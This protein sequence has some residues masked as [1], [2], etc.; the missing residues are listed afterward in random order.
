[1]RPLRYGPQLLPGSGFNGCQT[2]LD[3][4]KFAALF[5][6]SYYHPACSCRLGE[7]GLGL[8]GLDLFCVGGWGRWADRWMLLCGRLKRG[9]AA[10]PLPPVAPTII[11]SYIIPSGGRPRPEGQGRRARPPPRRRLR[12]AGHGLGRACGEL[13]HAGGPLRAADLG[14]DDGGGGEEGGRERP[15]AAARGAAVIWGLHMPWGVVFAY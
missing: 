12:A 1:M 5:S 4:A 11:L 15:P 14:G 9:G 3:T 10:H 7:V 6:G 2:L 13:L 8:G